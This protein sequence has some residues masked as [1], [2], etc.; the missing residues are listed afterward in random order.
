VKKANGDI[1]VLCCAEMFHLNETINALTQPLMGDSKLL[2]VPSFGKRDNGTF[3]KHLIESN[4]NYK[5][6]MLNGISNINILLPF[7]MAL[8]REQYIAIGGYDEDFTGIASDDIDFVDRL[9]M[10][11]CI[12]HKTNAKTVHLYHPR[13]WEQIGLNCPEYRHNKNLWL[14]RK[15][16]IVRNIG[17]EWGKL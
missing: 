14:S 12:Y 15:G 8:S 2:V 13:Y 11:G 9:K 5:S 4:G 6:E 16:Q 3:L 7:L 10:N 1:L 17:R